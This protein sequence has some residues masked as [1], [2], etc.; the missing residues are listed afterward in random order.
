MKAKMRSSKQIPLLILAVILLLGLASGVNAGI[1]CNIS[2]I[3]R[4]SKLIALNVS[5]NTSTDGSAG[6]VT[7]AFE[8]RDTTNHINS[9]YSLIG[10]ISNTT[11]LTY[12]NMTFG[13]NIIFPDA[14]NADLRATCI[15]NASGTAAGSEYAKLATAV[16]GIEVDR[17][18]PR[19]I[20]L[21]SPVSGVSTNLYTVTFGVI[22]ATRWRL[23]HNSIVDQTTTI[24]S[25]IANSSEQSRQISLRD[26]GSYYVETFD[27]TNTTNSETI[28]YTVQ[29]KL[30]KSTVKQTAKKVIVE[31]KKIQQQKSNKGIL[32]IG[33]LLIMGIIIVGA[34]INPKIRRKGR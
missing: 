26:S 16:T 8:L 6:N 12:V 5:F 20:G 23:F 13:D 30:I 14:D 10:N 27:G 34:M 18:V 15:L 11:S 19:T 28:S 32:L 2:S 31:K 29:G 21:S 7:V 4:I 22:N 17:T 25:D 1:D 24:T 3:T 9:S 33:G